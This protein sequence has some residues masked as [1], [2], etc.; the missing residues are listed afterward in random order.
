LRGGEVAV[1]ANGVQRPGISEVRWDAT[2]VASGIY[3]YR[4][5]S[6]DQTITRKMVVLK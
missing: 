3:F 4:L 2:N 5:Q 6:G 1:L